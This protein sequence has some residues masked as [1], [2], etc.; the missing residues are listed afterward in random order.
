MGRDFWDPSTFGPVLLGADRVFLLRP[1]PISR[2]GP[3]LNRF[4]DA[5]RDR[6]VRHVVFSSVAGAESNRIV[7]HHRVEEHLLSSGL[8]WTTL[9]PGFS[10]QNL[11]TAYR[12]DI[13]GSNRVY[14]P[15]GDGLAAFIDSRD[16]GEIAARALVEEG[17][18]GMAYHLTGPEAISFA[19]LTSIL[20]D[21]LG[22]PIA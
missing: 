15:A 10:A 20:S 18:V 14:V 13:V 3:T 2:V 4:I 21:V 5:A 22:R 6:G 9:R 17:H 7:P 16:I 8:A 12:S 11:A 1:P 19:D